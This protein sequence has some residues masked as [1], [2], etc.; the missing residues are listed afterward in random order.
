MILLPQPGAH[1]DPTAKTAPLEMG[2]AVADRSDGADAYF[3]VL[4]K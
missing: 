4:A 1:S 2:G 3:S